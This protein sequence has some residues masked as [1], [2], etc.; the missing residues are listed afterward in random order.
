MGGRILNRRRADIARHTP[1]RVGQPLGQRAIILGQGGGDLPRGGSAFV[2]ENRR[3]SFRYNFLLPA[4]RERPSVALSPGTSG[5]S[6][7][8]A[9]AGRAGSSGG[10]AG[11]FTV[12]TKRSSVSKSEAGSIGLDTCPFMPASRH[13]CRSSIVAWAVMATIGKLANRGSERIFFVAW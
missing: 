9:T 8:S 6:S 11:P 2:L 10:T 7:A 12:A 13:F 5:H 3:R 1:D 4:T